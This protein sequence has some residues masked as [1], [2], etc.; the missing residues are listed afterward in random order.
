MVLNDDIIDAS[1]AGLCCMKHRPIAWIVCICELK[2]E[3]AIV[4]MSPEMVNL[5]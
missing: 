2:D 1:G 5:F 4:C 3:L